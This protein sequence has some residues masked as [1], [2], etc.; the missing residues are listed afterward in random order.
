MP[1]YHEVTG[2]HA[3]YLNPV[4]RA[5]ETKKNI[6][7]VLPKKAQ[8]LLDM[9]I[10]KYDGRC[11][12]EA[13]KWL[14]AIDEWIER[15]DLRRT[16]AFDQLLFEEAAI[17]WKNFKTDKTTDDNA[18]EWFKETFT[19]KR[20][21]TDKIMELAVIRQDDNE[22][23]ATF[24]IRVLK[25]VREVMNS[26]MKEEDIANDLITTRVRDKRLR[27]DLITKPNMT[28]KDRNELAKIYEKVETVEKTEDIL[29]IRNLTYADATRNKKF[30]KNTYESNRQNLRENSNR[31][32]DY[33]RETP[34]NRIDRNEKRYDRFERRDEP[35]RMPTVS[36]KHIAKQVYNRHRGLPVPSGGE[37]RSGQCFCCGEHGHM[38][39][40]CPLKDKCLICGKA[41]H[42]FNDCYLLNKKEGT[43]SNYSRRIACIH[44]EEQED[45]NSR[46]DDNDEFNDEMQNHRVEKEK[47]A[48]DPIAYISSMGL[49]V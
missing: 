16:E 43:S 25:L 44:E 9:D 36:L 27:D 5:Q 13:E 46:N 15:N 26:G 10:R 30:V 49:R 33:R 23:Y 35:K 41:G 18:K 39:F 2:D 31:R 19:I 6:R 32:N 17:L 8:E 21:I 42:N 14:K 1:I 38:R 40:Q 7:D 3:A 29:A 48:R 11:A 4:T 12:K 47:N 45:L 24:E 37:I 28:P 34:D 20:S 22:R